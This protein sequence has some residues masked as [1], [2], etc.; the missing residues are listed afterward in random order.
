MGIKH[1]QNKQRTH[2]IFCMQTYTDGLRD[3]SLQN[4]FLPGRILRDISL[5]ISN[6]TVRS[7][8]VGRFAPKQIYGSIHQFS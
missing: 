7:K 1:E 4:Q 3:G 6:G 8:V 2:Y 5:K